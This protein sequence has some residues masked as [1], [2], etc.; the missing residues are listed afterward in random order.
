NNLVGDGLP[1]GIGGALVPEA[2]ASVLAGDKTLIRLVVQSD[3]GVGIAR[4]LLVLDH[5][6]ASRPQPEIQNV[7][8]LSEIV[9]VGRRNPRLRAEQWSSKPDADLDG[10]I[11]AEF[12]VVNVLIVSDLQLHPDDGLR[13]LDDRRRRLFHHDSVG[14]RCGLC[15]WGKSPA[16]R[17][18]GL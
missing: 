15:A 18:R 5:L 16:T 7:A 13:R 17:I 4:V 2:P 10:A 9:A 11:R 14:V 1:A 8:P 3:P 12:P 6:V